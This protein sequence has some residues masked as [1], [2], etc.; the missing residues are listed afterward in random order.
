MALMDAFEWCMRCMLRERMRRHESCED[1]HGS[2]GAASGS[3]NDANSSDIVGAAANT[4]NRNLIG[5]SQIS[6]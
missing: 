5:F 1:G 6:S 4:F 3:K 2:A